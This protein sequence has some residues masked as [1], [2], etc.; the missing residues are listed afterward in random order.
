MTIVAEYDSLCHAV[1]QCFL[2]DSNAATPSLSS[3]KLTD[4]EK[5][6]VQEH[7][8]RNQPTHWDIMFQVGDAL[9]SYRIEQPPDEL[10][11]E[12]TIAVRIA[13]HAVRF[14]TY[15]GPVNKGSGS[16]EIAE[17]GTYEVLSET[18]DERKLLLN[19]KILKGR[20]TL[21]RISGDRWLFSPS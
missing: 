4:A 21:K 5:F 18:K 13:D 9:Q 2:S 19:G 1:F 17:A 7:S 6:V 20:F 15:E 14:L 16:V 3:G 12:G 8:R 11:P 10:E